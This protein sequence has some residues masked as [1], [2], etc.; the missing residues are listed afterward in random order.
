LKISFI[1]LIKSAYG[2][3]DEN[4]RHKLSI[5]LVCLLISVIIWFT[6]KLSDEYDTV[7][8]VP[9]TF[10]HI[11]KNRVLTSV[12]DSI[13]QVEIVEKGSNLFRMLY[14]EDRNPVS[15]SLRFV[16]MY[17]KSGSY[18]GIII[19]TM[20][21]NE[22]EREQNLLGKIL[23]ISPDTIYLTFE[24]EKTRKI[25]VRANFEMTFEKQFMRYGAVEFNPDCVIVKGPLALMDRLDSI[26][27]GN[28]KL[29]QLHENYSGQKVFP[30]DSINRQ[31]TI[32]PDLVLFNVPVEKFTEAELE[33]PVGL[34]NSNGQQV[35]VFPD[36][37]KVFYTVALKDYTKVEPGMIVASADISTPNLTE[38]GKVRVNI[39]SYPPYISINKV[40]PEKVEFI[41]IK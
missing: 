38:D 15:I 30:A 9:V 8:E 25:P 2:K 12:S 14:V 4:F 31:L 13:L 6:I 29:D 7:I 10:T 23:S 1:D 3:R 20:L 39:E 24:P 22:I 35:K 21:I 33:V 26:S 16:P 32:T 5:F 27:L 40:E 19:P 36:K 18:Q 11:P 28:I 34:V 37:V 41:I 17:L